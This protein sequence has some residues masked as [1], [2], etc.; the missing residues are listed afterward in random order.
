M[1]HLFNK[2]KVE[3]FASVDSVKASKTFSAPRNGFSG[4]RKE[5]Y[6]PSGSRAFVVGPAG[7]EPATSCSQSKRATK[8]RYG[9]VIMSLGITFLVY[10]YLKTVCASR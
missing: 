9:P 10:T 5:P 6:F 8:L 1:N 2:Y 3:R 4:K 7:F